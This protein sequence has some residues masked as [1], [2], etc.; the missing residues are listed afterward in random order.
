[1]IE[2]TSKFNPSC[3]FDCAMKADI[4]TRMEGYNGVDKVDMVC[5]GKWG[6]KL[7]LKL[8]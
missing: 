5:Y 3:I 6:G 8:G 2:L 1:M 4:R 7:D